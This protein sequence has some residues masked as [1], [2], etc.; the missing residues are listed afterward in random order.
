M[1]LDEEQLQ[2]LLHGQL[3]SRAARSARDHLAEC[4]DCRERFVAAE[5][6]D[7]RVLALLRQVDHAVPAIDPEALVARLRWTT[8]A[9]GRWAA[10]ILLFLG[11]VGAAYALPGSPLRHWVRTAVAWI[12]GGETPPGQPAAADAPAGSVAGIAALPG[13]RFVIEFQS[14]EQGGKAKVS[15][16]DRKEVTVRAPAGAA[17]FT[18]R[19]GRLIVVN[20]GL[21]AQ[22]EIGIPRT[23]PRVEIRVAGATVFVKDGSRV[24]SDRSATIAGGY[25]VSLSPSRP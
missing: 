25:L 1:H 16:S 15:L 4:G 23:A 2:R 14:A 9:W 11:V 5:R 20:A 13:K 18:S 17:S 10:A 6:A 7:K 19:A 22:Y 21:G 12:G 24:T 3:P 8:P